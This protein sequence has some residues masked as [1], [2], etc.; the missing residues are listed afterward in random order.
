MNYKHTA[1]TQR[2]NQGVYTVYNTLVWLC[3]EGV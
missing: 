1:V 2:I 3:G